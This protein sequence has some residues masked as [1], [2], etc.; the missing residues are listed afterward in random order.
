MVGTASK[1]VPETTPKKT[2]NFKQ[3][4]KEII[5]DEVKFKNMRD[6]Q[7]E[8]V[9]KYEKS[10]EILKSKLEE[11]NCKIKEIVERKLFLE[12]KINEK[13]PESLAIDKYKIQL[14]EHMSKFYSDPWAK[15]HEY[16]FG[17]LPVTLLDVK[18]A[19]EYI[20]NIPNMS[21]CRE[22]KDKLTEWIELN[23]EK[24]VQACKDK[25][26]FIDIIIRIRNILNVYIGEE[27]LSKTQVYKMYDVSQ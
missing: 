20:K 2:V 19:V 22:Y 9:L 24:I 10:L 15:I 7:E 21:V 5:K 18:S 3:E 27:F 1:S 6:Q 4:L 13:S 12:K 23:T 25:F 26:A 8:H 17:Y 16:S 11:Y 14:A